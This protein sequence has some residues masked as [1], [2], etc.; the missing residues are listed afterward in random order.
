LPAGTKIERK[1]DPIFL[2][3]AKALSADIPFA[4]HSLAFK[5]DHFMLDVWHPHSIGFAGRVAYI[6]AEAWR[7]SAYITF[8]GQLRLPPLRISFFAVSFTTN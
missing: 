6:V 2:Q 3:G 4:R 7:L 8:A 5:L 1:L